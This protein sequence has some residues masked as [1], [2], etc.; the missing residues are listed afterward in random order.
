MDRKKT[1]EWD[2]TYAGGLRYAMIMIQRDPFA[3]AFEWIVGIFRVHAIPFQLSGG[4]AARIYGS[5]RELRDLDFDIPDNRIGD[6][7]VLLAP[8]VR[9]GPERTRS[10]AFE[11]V[12]LTLCY[13]GVSI[14]IGG[15]TTCRIFDPRTDTWEQCASDFGVFSEEEVY[16]MVVP[17]IRPDDLVGYKSVNPRAEDLE[18]IV[19]VR[20]VMM[21]SHD[22]G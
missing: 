19:A 17:V 6:V 14:D 10:R 13:G 7:A 12:L 1:G 8:F 22:G 5:P 20:R 21:T 4:L 11:N 3:V 18:D 16:G 9:F 15:G 2:S